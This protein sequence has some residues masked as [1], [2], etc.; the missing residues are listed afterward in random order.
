[1]IS[2][3]HTWRCDSCGKF[4]KPGVNRCMICCIDLEHSKQKISEL[5]GTIHENNSKLG[6]FTQ[7]I[8][9][10]HK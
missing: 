1:M 2:N 7:A 10:E 8:Q 9:Q 4:V 5:I 3:T 6:W